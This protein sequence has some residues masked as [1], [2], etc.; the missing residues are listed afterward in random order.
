M[1]TLRAT[2]PL[3]IDGVVLIPVQRVRVEVSQGCAGVCMHAFA[4]PRAVVVRS[5]GR[6]H[7]IDPAGDALELEP[8][9]REVA[10]LADALE[11]ERSDS[12]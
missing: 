6:W 1:E 11:R 10:G 8:L 4:D 12:T 5:H 9:V 2:R 7:A 3:R